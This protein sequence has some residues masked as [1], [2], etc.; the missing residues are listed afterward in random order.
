MLPVC[1]AVCLTLAGCGDDAAL[2]DN[3][4]SEKVQGSSVTIFGENHL[5]SDGSE[6]VWDDFYFTDEKENGEIGYYRVS[7][8]QG[9]SS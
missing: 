9:S 4:I 1:I 5:S 7:F 3:D 2:P 6:L 8:M